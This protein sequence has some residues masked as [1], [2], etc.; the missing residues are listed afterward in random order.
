[1]AVPYIT[2]LPEAPSPD[3]DEGIFDAKAFEHVKALHQWT[4]EVTQVGAFC[5]YQAALSRDHANRSDIAAGVA[6]TQFELAR[7]QAGVAMMTAHYK[8]P[9]SSLV[10]ALARPASVSHAGLFWALNVDLANVATSEPGANDNWTVLPGVVELAT[11]LNVS[12]ASGATG[13]NTPTTLQGSTFASVYVG[14]T[15]ANSQW[16]INTANAFHSPIH[17]SGSIAGS[18]SYVVPNGVL[19]PS[20]QYW[21]RVRYRSSRG[22]WSAW[23]RATP[24]TTAAAFGQYIPVP[25][26]T[27]ASF[28]KAFQGGYY[29]GLIWQE[30]AR[31]THSKAIATGASV[32]FTLDPEYDMFVKPLVYVGQRLD[33]RSRANPGNRFEGTVVTA[34]G[35]A[36]TINVTSVSGSGT[37]SDWSVMARFRCIVAPKSSGRLT[38]WRALKP[39]G[40]ALPAA[41]V[42]LTDGLLA[43]NAMVA[44]GDATVYPLAHWARNLTIGGYTD[45][46]LPARDEIELIARNLNNDDY[47]TVGQ[48]LDVAL[49][50]QAGAWGYAAADGIGTNR[51]SVPQGSAYPGTVTADLG[52]DFHLA[53]QQFEV[54][55]YGIHM[56]SSTRHPSTVTEAATMQMGVAAGDIYFQGW[57][58]AANSTSRG[59]SAMRRSIV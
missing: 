5:E 56:W 28:G 45:W 24:F 18:I 17:D 16:Q 53:G 10:G 33:V 11:P 7:E 2:P 21:W 12:P 20:T 38:D 43:T 23:S 8:G 3:D 27:P 4:D 13:V 34:D 37:F 15:H 49:A 40:G 35:L 30:I 51:N 19:S 42:T 29:A 1:M 39:G 36:L 6:E 55:N 57:F 48:T 26:A 46:Y 47:C 32:V 14:N 52:S 31:A 54:G 22:T 44:D 50:A 59:C 25:A 9:W 58:D 41:C